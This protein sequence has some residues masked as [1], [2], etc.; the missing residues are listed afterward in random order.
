MQFAQRLKE[1]RGKRGLT[2]LELSKAIDISNR[3]LCYYETGDRFPKD[4]QLLI[5]IAD[6]FGVSLDY[7]VGR[8]EI[9]YMHELDNNTL[10]ID[11]L[12]LNQEERKKIIDYADMILQLH[13]PD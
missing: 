9:P 5:R 7:L 11:V 6:F 10:Y 8:T 2:Q 3:V 13:K 12:R 4:E 1:L